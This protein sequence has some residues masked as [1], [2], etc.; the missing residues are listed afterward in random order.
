MLAQTSISVAANAL[1]TYLT[2]NIADLDGVLIS[3]PKDA[4][5]YANSEG[6]HYLNLFFYQVEYSGYP[7]DGISDDPFYLQV[8]CLITPLGSK[9]PGPP[10]ISVSA[11]E[12]D[13]RLMGEVLRLLH[14]EPILM[15]NEGGETAQLQVVMHPLSLDD[16]NHLWSNQGDVPYRL[17]VAYQLSLLPVPL[18]AAEERSPLV[19][20]VGTDVYGGMT[21]PPLPPGGFGLET[22]VPHLTSLSTDISRPD[23]QPHLIF[24]DN[25]GR[26]SYSLSFP[27]SGLPPALDV[28]V[29][30]RAGESVTLGWQQWDAG[31]GPVPWRSVGTE[32]DVQAVTAAIDYEQTDPS[33]PSLVRKVVPVID[34]AGQAVLYAERHFTRS[35]STEVVL[36]SNPLLLIVHE[37][38]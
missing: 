7:A 4:A 38:V 31:A 36:R 24:L 23:W 8:N 12:N 29:L 18:G 20:A 35:D 15:V 22:A 6:K 3:H 28:I 10:Q 32:Q 9:E 33:L 19:E 16:I 1:R 2:N 5:E 27:L 11:G 30:G 26:L 17:S 14:E 25:N 34:V 13:L 21:V 37:E